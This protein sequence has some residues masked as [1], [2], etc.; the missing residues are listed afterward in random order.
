MEHLLRD[1]RIA[2]RALGHR[3]GFAAVVVVT[4]ALAIG[5]NSAIFSVVRGVLLAPPPYPEPDRLLW[6]WQ[7][8]RVRGTDTEGFSVPDY[9]DLR[10][11]TRAFGELAALRPVSLGL[12]GDG[13]AERLQAARVSADFFAALGVRPVLGRGF[14]EA[15]DAEGA[16]PVTVISEGLWRRRFGG[17]P[18]ILGRRL[19]LDQV[20]RT[21]VGVMPSEA[22]I[23]PDPEQLW[24][25]A[26]WTEV[27]R[28]DDRR[29]VHNQAVLAR[30][31]PGVSLER[32]EQEAAAV[33]ARLEREHPDDNLGR[34]ARLVAF[35]EQAVGG[36][37][38]ALAALAA[39]VGAVLLVAC[40]NVANLMLARGAGRRREIALRAA[41]GAG[42]G[43]VVQQL[44]VESLVLAAAGGALGLLL[45][46][47]SLDALIALGGGGVPRLDEVRLDG[48]V[49]G[50]TA[51]LSLATG[52][53]FGLLPALRA[54]RPDLRATLLDGGRGGGRSAGRQRLRRGLVVAE[55]ALSVMLVIAAGLLIRSFQRVLA[56][57][58]GLDP[59]GV[60]TVQIELP[61]ATYPFP[62]GWPVFD[63]P[64]GVGFLREL[65]ERV[66]R[67]PG[68]A[69]AATALNAPLAAGWTTRVTVAGRPAVPEGEQEEAW[70]RPVGPGYFRLLAIPRVAGREFTAADDGSAPRVAVVDQA[71]V[72]RWFPGASPIGESIEIFGVPREIVGV[73]GEVR[74]R[75]LEAEVQPTMY[76]PLHQSPMSALSLVVRAEVRAEG[77]PSALL[78]EV[79]RAVAAIDPD[80]PV[81]GAALLEESISG[82]LAE[83]R[84][85]LFLLSLF[86]A[87]ALVLAAVG[88]YGTVA[89]GVAERRHEIGV[90]LALGGGRGDVLRMVLTEGLGLALAGVALGVAG[91]LAARKALSALVFDIGTA[92]PATYAAV[93]VALAAVALAASWIPARRATAVDPA[94]VLQHE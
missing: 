5:A 18:G 49:L 34:G 68:V 28:G 62:E 66:E 44:L 48:W 57:D 14:V 46:S 26:A 16:E 94:V 92:D 7:T 45:A 50:F 70:F 64:R 58:P 30:L 76:V 3:H 89:L 82:S 38:P 9:L 60:V 29:G 85:T 36:V 37:R 11:G 77:E 61:Q 47:W 75:G 56:L 67:L 35:H 52:L 78:P 8:D 42:R 53:A 41:L 51:A 59:E 69:G 22:G 87:L 43:R 84:F 79:R 32:A 27:E 19:R 39:A 40:A 73:V 15:D 13:E 91:A 17:D 23:P 93:A 25:P 65:E 83:R 63:W 10:A 2:F 4:L 24:I 6:L 86:A 81:F 12:T 88:I 1:L 74:H 20:E 31:A 21:V 71:F 55:V 33:M 54:S 90:R 72:R 80:L